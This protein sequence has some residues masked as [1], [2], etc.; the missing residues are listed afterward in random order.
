MALR[1]LGGGIAS[2]RKAAPEFPHVQIANRTCQPK[3]VYH[4]TVTFFVKP[5]HVPPAARRQLPGGKAVTCTDDQQ[6]R[7]HDARRQV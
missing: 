5:L 4:V 1:R 3:K 6:L 2:C 7:P